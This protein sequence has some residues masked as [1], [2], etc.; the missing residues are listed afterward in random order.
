MTVRTSGVWTAR[1]T[2]SDRRHGATPRPRIW[3]RRRWRRPRRGHGGWSGLRQDRNLNEA[4]ETADPLRLMRL[5]GISEQT[6]RG[7]HSTP[8]QE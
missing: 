5:F 7:T 8:G 3:R 2:G 6:R 1:C 4:F